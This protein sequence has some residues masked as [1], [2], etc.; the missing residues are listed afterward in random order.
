[1]PHHEDHVATEALLELHHRKRHR[2]SK[3]H[4]KPTTTA[5]VLPLPLGLSPVAV[6][7]GPSA[8]S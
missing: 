4:R 8:S 7:L 1:M 6:S 2:R 5:P 3:H